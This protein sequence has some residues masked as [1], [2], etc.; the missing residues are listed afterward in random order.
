MIHVRAAAV[1]NIRSAACI[2]LSGVRFCNAIEDMRAFLRRHSEFLFHCTKTPRNRPWW[3]LLKVSKFVQRGHW[4]NLTEGEN[5]TLF[6]RCSTY[7][8]HVFEETQIIKIIWFWS[9]I[10]MTGLL[11]IQ[12]KTN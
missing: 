10:I 7:N 3:K 12:L 8:A 9:D 2:D 5:N 6:A 4:E 11:T 1:K